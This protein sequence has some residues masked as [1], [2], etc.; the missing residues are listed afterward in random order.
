MST[1]RI[2][3]ALEQIKEGI[4]FYQ[5]HG[6]KYSLFTSEIHRLSA[7]ISLFGSTEGKIAASVEAYRYLPQDEHT[8]RGGADIVLHRF[9]LAGLAIGDLPFL[10]EVAARFVHTGAP[11][12]EEYF[13]LYQLWNGEDPREYINEYAGKPNAL[14]DAAK[15]GAEADGKLPEVS[16]AVFTCEIIRLN[17]LLDIYFAIELL[18]FFGAEPGFAS[19]ISSQLKKA[20]EFI[21]SCELP[22]F[23]AAMTE[24]YSDYLDPKDIKKWNAKLAKLSKRE[25]SQEADEY[26][27]LSMLGVIEFKHPDGEIER[28]RGA[29]LRSVLGM[30]T[31]N[32][33]LSDP[34]SRNEFCFVAA[35]EKDDPDLA[36]KTVNMA[37]SSLRD[38]LG[39]DAII[40]TGETPALNL[41][42]VKVDLIE[43]SDMLDDAARSV[44]R[45][46]IMRAYPDV[47]KAMEMALG[48]VPFP[49]LYDNLFEALREDF[50]SRMRKVTLD[51]GRRLDTE[52]DHKSAVILLRK[53]VAAIPDDEEVSEL[54]AQSLDS[55]GQKAEAERIRMKMKE[56]AE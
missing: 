55:S 1:G 14:L 9:L 52:G 54:L 11:K 16:K 15:T 45:G 42:R 47:M 43:A 48:K 25:A 49:T 33:M 28:V 5:S 26:I 20:F 34:L 18:R 10:R 39:D 27:R 19:D 8:L 17:D 46:S 13:A 37:I 12:I 44:R 36:R 21:V 2:K 29:R 3:D 41:E 56:A 51:L 30:M 4:H 35:G 38:D 24:R 40:T 7:E 31:A 6:F 22:A 53:Y 32:I 50:D 23:A